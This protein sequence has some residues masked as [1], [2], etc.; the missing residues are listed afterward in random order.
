MGFLV[1]EKRPP[2][3]DPSLFRYFIYGGPKIGKTTLASRFPDACFLAAEQGQGALEVASTPLATWVEFL[4]ACAELKAGAHSFKTVI[5]DT[6]D[7]LYDLCRIHVCA[8]LGIDHEADIKFGVGHAKIRAEFFRALL[9]LADLPLG[10]VFISHTETKIFRDKAGNEVGRKV[11]PSFRAGNEEDQTRM[12]ALADF[13]LYCEQT[14][15]FDSK[16]KMLDRRVL[17]SKPH[18]V[19]MA[20]SR[21]P[22]SD[23][24]PLSFASL[25][26]AILESIRKV[27][28]KRQHGVTDAAPEQLPQAQPLGE[29]PQPKEQPTEQPTEEKG[30]EA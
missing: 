8:K 26:S 2:V 4:T 30:A 11:C 12:L 3:T 7:V 10:L 27:Q 23:P 14:P 29:Q 20:G 19:Y 15:E 17:H 9:K 21:Y 28:A 22:L 6:A 18:P 5:V 24:L 1:L 25:H 16:G 13:I